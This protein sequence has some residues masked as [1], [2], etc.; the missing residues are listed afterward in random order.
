MTRWTPHDAQ[1]QCAVRSASLHRLEDSQHCN[2]NACSSPE[3]VIR[4]GRSL[5]HLHPD[6]I[7]QPLLSVVDFSHITQQL[8]VKHLGSHGHFQLIEGVL[9]DIVAVELVYPAN[10]DI[11]IR[12][13]CVREEQKLDARQR[14]EAL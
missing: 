1:L 14:V 6:C 5:L 11:D 4:L 2:A 13:R 7:R 8:A 3:S 9:H 10:G 12:L